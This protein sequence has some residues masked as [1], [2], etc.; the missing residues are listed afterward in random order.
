M[1]TALVLLAIISSGAIR[2]PPWSIASM[3]LKSLDDGL[4]TLE[5]AKTGDKVAVAK[6]KYRLRGSAMFLKQRRYADRRLQAI[7]GLEK[8]LD[9]TKES[10]RAS[11][12]ELHEWST[13]L[14][15]RMPRSASQS[16]EL[17]EI[18]KRIEA[19]WTAAAAQTA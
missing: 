12:K 16:G 19:R 17:D 8:L 10:E 15:E 1:A 6:A 2:R 13:S 14:R 7:L 11:W 5:A 18:L 4:S 9:F 3:W